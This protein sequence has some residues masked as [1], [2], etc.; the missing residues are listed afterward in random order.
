MVVLIFD[1]HP[2]RTS[3]KEHFMKQEKVLSYTVSFFS[4]IQVNVESDNR[5]S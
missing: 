5:H 1:D 2:S 3:Y 4:H